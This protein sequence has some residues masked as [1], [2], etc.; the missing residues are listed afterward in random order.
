[1]QDMMKQFSM[2]GMDPNMFP[3]NESLV[4]NKNH[5][6]VK[7]TLENA[8]GQDETAQMVAQQIYDLA[9]MSHKPLEADAMTAFIKTFKRNYETYD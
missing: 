1:M 6:L 5:P 9:M 7:Y 8:E 2:S 3:S 4:L